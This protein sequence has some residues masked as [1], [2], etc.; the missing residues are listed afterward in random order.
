MYWTILYM[1]G[2]SLFMLLHR[3]WFSPDQFVVFAMIGVVFLGRGKAFVRDWAPFLLF[4]FA[5]EFLRG[6]VPIVNHYVH[7]WPMIRFDETVFGGIPDVFLQSHLYTPGAIHWYDYLAVTSYISYFVVPMLAAYAFWLYDRATF[8]QFSRA[9]L[10]LAYAAFATYILFPAMPPWM[11]AQA[12]Y[13]PPIVEITPTVMAHFF[14][15]TP[16]PSLYN[17]LRANPVAAMPSLHAAMPFLVL[18]YMVRKW[19][20]WGWLVLP[21][22]ISVWFAVLYLGEHYVLDVLVGSIYA[23]GVFWVT[24]RT[25]PVRKEKYTLDLAEEVEDVRV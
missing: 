21:Y 10:Y 15:A 17:F 14:P 22:V 2:V 25:R 24:T 19:K 7:I 4:Y 9:F 18:L 12:G 8:L 11:A 23:G 3:L 1:V 13:I 5:Y 6:I 16:L 20:K